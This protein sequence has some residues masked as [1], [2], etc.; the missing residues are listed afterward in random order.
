M[1][2]HSILLKGGTV[3]LHNAEDAVI[4]HQHTDLLLVGN[5]I[6]EIGKSLAAPPG[7]QIIDRTGKKISP[8]FIDTHHHLW[9]T[10]LKSRHEDHSLFEYC[11]SGIADPSVDSWS[12]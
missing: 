5:K 6:V 3:L 10:Q 12:V 4:P 1:A 7:A 2:T 11:Y 8:G 9:Q